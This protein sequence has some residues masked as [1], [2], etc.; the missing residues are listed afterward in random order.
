M[1]WEEYIGENTVLSIVGT[2]VTLPLD[3]V[4]DGEMWEIMWMSCWQVGGGNL[5]T[6]FGLTRS[7][8]FYGLDTSV[9][10]AA[11]NGQSTNP[12]AFL[13][14]GESPA[15]YFASAATAGTVTFRVAARRY[16]VR[17]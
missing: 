17:S 14:G 1:E 4:P 10:L 3:R 13:K 15:V 7:G 16:K 12:R 6:T 8:T 11:N 5:T 9:T 2:A